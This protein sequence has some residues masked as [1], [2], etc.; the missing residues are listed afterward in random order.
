MTH[1]MVMTKDDAGNILRG[2][3]KPD[4]KS[5]DEAFQGKLRTW[6][7]KNKIPDTIPITVFLRAKEHA[8]LRKMAVQVDRKV[9]GAII[10]LMSMAKDNAG[11]VLR[12][13]WKPD[14]QTIDEAFQRKLRAWIEKNNISNNPPITVFLN[15]RT[16]LKSRQKALKDLS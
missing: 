5:I 16:Y 9:E 8:K 12:E 1:E 13:R 11:N 3:W 4:G 14:G 6:M 15:A 2:C 7:K 10:Q